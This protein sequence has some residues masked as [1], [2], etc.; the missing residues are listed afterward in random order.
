[1]ESVEGEAFDA[2]AAQA[3]FLVVRKNRNAC[4]HWLVT[5]SQQIERGWADADSR[6]QQLTVLRECLL[7]LNEH[8]HADC[9]E[10]SRLAPRMLHRLDFEER[11]F[12]NLMLPIERK[13]SKG[14]ADHQF[15][16]LTDDRTQL[17]PAAADGAAADG[18]AADAAA[19]DGAAAEGFAMEGFAME[20]FAAE[21]AAMEGFAAE[22]A[23][24]EGAAA[25]ASADWLGTPSAERPQRDAAMALTLVLDHMRSA[26]NVGA[27]FRTAECLGFEKLVLCGYTATP[28][29]SQVE[30]TSMGTSPL[31]PWE[32]ER[33]TESALAKLRI[34]G[35]PII[36]L[37]TVS[38]APLAHD[39]RFPTTRCALVLGNERH[40]ISPQLLAHCDAIVRLPSN[41]LKNSL[42]VG[43]ALGM[44]GYEIY[45]QWSG[46]AVGAADQRGGASAYAEH[47]PYAQTPA[48]PP[49]RV[50]GGVGG[51][52]GVAKSH[53]IQDIGAASVLTPCTVRILR[54]RGLL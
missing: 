35:V 47:Q 53:Q 19:A 21:R 37:E 45:R 32:Y 29:D 39:F 5:F 44:C 13:Y 17:E 54:W 9:R 4:I 11:H 18:A 8:P 22:G 52:V 46:G 15:L 27:I 41:G 38:D 31:V 3:S 10:L 48:T 25:A 43:V 30:R 33:S 49:S 7:S 40:G 2:A 23:A 1:M 14:L 28:D 16:V 34:E 50:G 26:F 20:G 51:G 42:N 24:A 6:L 12:L 36:A